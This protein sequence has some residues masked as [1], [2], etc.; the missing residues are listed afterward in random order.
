LNPSNCTGSHV[1]PMP[2]IF[3]YFPCH[4]SSCIS[5]VSSCIY[6][7]MYLHVLTLTS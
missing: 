7:A 5:H 4:L 2:C 6:H 1:F 3:M